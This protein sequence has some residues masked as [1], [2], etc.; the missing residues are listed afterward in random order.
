MPDAANYG[1]FRLIHFQVAPMISITPEEENL[2]V[3][4][5]QEQLL[6]FAGKFP[7]MLLKHE[8]KLRHVVKPY[9]APFVNDDVV[10]AQAVLAHYREHAAHYMEQVQEY[11]DHPSVQI[12]A[13]D[14]ERVSKVVH[15]MIHDAQ[16]IPCL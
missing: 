13:E 1:I 10:E 12:G 5:L 2:I 7:S 16:D 4:A 11:L 3:L 15:D 6:G 9:L 14:V 8:D